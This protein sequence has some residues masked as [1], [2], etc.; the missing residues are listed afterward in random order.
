MQSY[1]SNPFRLIL[2]WFVMFS[3]YHFDFQGV[4]NAQ[5]Q[6]NQSASSHGS[7]SPG[8]INALSINMEDTGS[9]VGGYRSYE[10]HSRLSGSNG[11]CFDMDEYLHLKN[12]DD[13]LFERLKQQQRISSGG[14]L[15]CNRMLF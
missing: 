15:L 10:C 9:K 12:N 8:I 1:L 7:W 3:S 11:S 4:T 2:G 6:S 14:L 5:D 13:F